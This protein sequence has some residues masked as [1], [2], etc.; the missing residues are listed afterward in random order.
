MKTRALVVLVVAGAA[1]IT[2]IGLW[3]RSLPRGNTENAVSDSGAPVAEPVST[4]P[5]A[6]LTN[7]G[8]VAPEP[9]AVDPAWRTPSSPSPRYAEPEEIERQ[10]AQ[11]LAAQP[12]LEVVSLSSIH[13][14]ATT[15]EIALTGNEVNPRY[16][17]AYHDLF[18]KVTSAG[19]NDFRIRSAG[20]G[21]REIAP[22]AR[23]YVI[24]FEYQPLVDLSAD[25]LIAARQ[26]AAC[27]AA[28]RRATENPTPD[29]IARSYLDTAEHYVALAASVL[30]EQEAARVAAETRGGP[31]LR[32]CF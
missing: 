15:C 3:R 1:V 11:F 18:D 8:N 14:G 7:T 13:C 4:S 2:A 9:R 30:G 12:G 16:V 17:D 23:E 24:S 29:D 5:S 22:G 19:G 25:P 6:D 28:W 27:A 32:D 26:Y 21:T 10:L 31:V 20:L